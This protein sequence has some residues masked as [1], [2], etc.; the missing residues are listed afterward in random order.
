MKNQGLLSFEER[1]QDLGR[2]LEAEKEAK[3]ALETELAYRDETTTELQEKLKNSQSRILYLE[4]EI[5]KGKGE[6][7]EVQHQLSDIETEKA[8]AVSKLD[9]LKSASDANSREL[10]RA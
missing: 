9:Q 7:E 1:L 4:G 8:M 3:A 5:A 2:Q 6:I 10:E